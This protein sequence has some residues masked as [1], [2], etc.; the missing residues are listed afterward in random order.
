MNSVCS[1]HGRSLKLAAWRQDLMTRSVV[2]AEDRD[3]DLDCHVAIEAD[4]SPCNRD[5][6]SIYDVV[7]RFYSCTTFHW[8][9]FVSIS[10][11]FHI[12]ER[13][14]QSSAYRWACGRSLS[15]WG[16]S[17]STTHVA[18][19]QVSS[20]NFSGGKYFWWHASWSVYQYSPGWSVCSAAWRLMKLNSLRTARDTWIAVQ[21]WQIAVHRNPFDSSLSK[22]IMGWIFSWFSVK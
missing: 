14:W 15:Y 20:R 7:T 10:G 3:R 4:L 9:V 1:R 22:L 17:S 5:V 8:C 6:W 19:R 18:K 11:S 13:M 16:K 2:A 21:L 12:N